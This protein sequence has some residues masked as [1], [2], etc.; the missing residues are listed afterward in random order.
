MT[1]IIRMGL[2]DNHMKLND[3]SVYLCMYI[4]PIIKCT[5]VYD[6]VQN[7]VQ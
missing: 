1:E 5:S 6:D 3:H 7:D 4:N 2:K